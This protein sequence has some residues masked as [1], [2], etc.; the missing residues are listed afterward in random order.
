MSVSKT[1][2]LPSTNYTL[3]PYAISSV[4]GRTNGTSY[5]FTTDASILF[6]SVG[7]YIVA[8]DSSNFYFTGTISN[9]SS[10][11]NIINHGFLIGDPANGTLSII[12]NSEIIAATLS[13]GT[14]SS[15]V[16][17]QVDAPNLEYFYVRAFI[18]NDYETIYSQQEI[19]QVTYI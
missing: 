14:L 17:G 6:G 8:T 15:V 11:Y 5:N 3:T 7:S 18:T 10:Q 2:L 4:Y 12:N 9:V 16:E 1:G 19:I 13:S